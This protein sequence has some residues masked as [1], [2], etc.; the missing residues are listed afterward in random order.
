MKLSPGTYLPCLHSLSSN[1]EN[2][3]SLIK[4]KYL[5]IHFKPAR[6]R[7]LILCQETSNK[8]QWTPHQLSAGMLFSYLHQFRCLHHCWLNS[9][10]FPKRHCQ[11]SCRLHFQ[12][13]FRVLSFQCR[14][15]V[16]KLRHQFRHRC[17]FHL[18]KE[19]SNS[20]LKLSL[21]IR[22]P[23]LELL[24]SFNYSNIVLK[25]YV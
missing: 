1:S 7:E 24:P 19:E 12:T 9:D 13:T 14:Q 3:L 20:I 2:F 21:I 18:F 15:A 4:T 6:F 11:W 23:C 16:S 10:P 25:H 8:K 22:E 17:D 5:S